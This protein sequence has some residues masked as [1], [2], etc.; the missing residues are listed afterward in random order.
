MRLF[1]FF[2]NLWWLVPHTPYEPAPEPHWSDTEAKGISDDQ[3]RF[4]SMMQHMDA[5]VGQVL[6][7]LDELG[8]AENTLVLFT[9][10][11][12][13]AWEGHIGSLKGGKTDLHEGGIRVPM[14]ARW[15]DQIPSGQQSRVLGHS[16]DLLPTICEAAGIQIPGTQELDGLSLLPHMKGA[17]APTNEERGTVFWQMILYKQLQRHYPKPEPFATEVV[18]RGQWKLL[19]LDGKPVELYDVI[20]DPN[21][22]NDV[23]FEHPKLV[24]SLTAEL[25]AWLAADRISQ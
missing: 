8:I 4:R 14:L 15:P 12:G 25:Q 6:N 16:T 11:S 21:E 13:A 18:K 17:P 24:A 20:A 10:D 9:S 7:K 19:A 5:K 23:M 22:L 2:L 1:S 3:H